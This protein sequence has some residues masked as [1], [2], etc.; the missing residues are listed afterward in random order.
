M[1]RG[2][3]KW[4]GIG[5]CCACPEVRAMPTGA[6]VA[7]V[8]V[9]CNDSYKYKSTGEKVDTTEFVRVV[10][11]NRL[12]EIAGQYLKKGSKIYV[13]GQLRTRKWEKDGVER[14]STEI[15][16]RDFQMLDSRGDGGPAGT[17]GTAGQ[18]STASADY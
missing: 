16:A 17:T 13:E 2:I 8:T 11:F 7:N 1:S 12:A 4:I 5:N 15:V 3:N 10:F 6:E 18:A 14:Y 9:A